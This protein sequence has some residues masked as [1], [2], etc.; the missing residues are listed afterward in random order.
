MLANTPNARCAP[1]FFQSLPR[2]RSILSAVC[3]ILS[4]FSCFSFPRVTPRRTARLRTRQK[5]RLTL[6]IVTRWQKLRKQRVNIRIPLELLGTKFRNVLFERK[7]FDVIDGVI[8]F[9][10]AGGV[11]E[12]SKTRSF[13]ILDG[14]NIFFDRLR[15]SDRCY[16][17]KKLF[18]IERLLVDISLVL[19]FKIS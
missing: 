2:N 19:I 18:I 11:S 12:I 5:A 8:I 9:L 4:C 17:K 14:F 3:V 13:L 15:L 1:T 7:L 16:I 10:V 6:E